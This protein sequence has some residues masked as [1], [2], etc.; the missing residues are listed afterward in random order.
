MPDGT[1]ITYLIDGQNRRIGKQV[2]GT[3]VQ[4]FLYEGELNPVAEMNGRGNVISRFVYA[5]RGN[6]PD[7]MINGGVTYRIISD[8]LGS[9]RLVVNTATGQAV[10]QLD[11]EASG[12]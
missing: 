8:T 10:Q 2:N 7:Y 9:P 4:G 1:Q 6:V 5:S 3:L 11:Y 12:N